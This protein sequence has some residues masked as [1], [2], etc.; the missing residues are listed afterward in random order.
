MDRLC[1]TES[2]VMARAVFDQVGLTTY[3]KTYKDGPFVFLARSFLAARKYDLVHVHSLDRLVPWLDRFYRK[4]PLV[5]LYHGTDILGRWD[6]KKS[7][8]QHADALAYSTSN[9]SEGAPSK[10][11]LM[12]NPVDT[13]L[14]LPRPGNRRLGTA[15]SIRYGMDAEAEKVAKSRSLELTWVERG[16]VPHKD[17]PSY[18]SQFE[19]FLD[20][21]RPTGFQAP[22][23]SVGRAALEALACGCKVIDWSGRVLHELPGENRPESVVKRWYTLY[24]GLVRG[25]E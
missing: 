9:L 3:G 6:Q 15:L 5:L 16:K 11:F 14:F 21:R 1:G 20:L 4:K 12:P 8:W 7:R 13:D 17:M 19:Y 25:S 22:V 24:Q 10:A 2:D 23:Q 18:F